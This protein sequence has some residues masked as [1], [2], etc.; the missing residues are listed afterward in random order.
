MLIYQCKL[1]CILS[2]NTARQLTQN[3][4]IALIL[5]KTVPVL[6]PKVNTTVGIKTFFV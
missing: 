5:Q 1:G 6:L 4:D 2:V 3:S